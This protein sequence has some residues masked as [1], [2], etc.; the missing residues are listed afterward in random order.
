MG[1]LGTNK[2]MVSFH[3]LDFMNKKTPG[4]SDHSSYD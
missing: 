3:L 4:T 2:P 1:D